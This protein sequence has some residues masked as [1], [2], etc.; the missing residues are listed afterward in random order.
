MNTLETHTE[1]QT[2]EERSLVLSLDLSRFLVSALLALAV[3]VMA[4]LLMRGPAPASAAGEALSAVTD[5]MR[6]FYLA[7]AVANATEAV[8][9]CESGYHFASLWEILDTSN[10]V[11]DTT[12]GVVPSGADAGSGPPTNMEGW[13]RTGYS[14]NNGINPGQANCLAWT[15]MT[16]NGSTVKLPYNWAT[17]GEIHVWDA[18]IAACGSASYV[19]CVEN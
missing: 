19:W 10:L 18:G 6:H 2:P 17:G 5:G 9:A 8:G 4:A 12:L 3:I 1:T 14:M 11:Y 7:P 15:A 16:G 13:V